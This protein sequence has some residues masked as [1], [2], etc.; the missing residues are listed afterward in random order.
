MSKQRIIRYTVL[1]II[2]LVILIFGLS[3]IGVYNSLVE[4]DENINF[5][6]AEVT[7][8]LKARHDKITLIAGAVNGLQDYA[9]DVYQMITDAR[10]AYNAAYAANDMEGLIEA[11][12]LESLALTSLMAVVEDNPNLGVSNVYTQYISEVSSIESSLQ[13]ARREYNKAI[14]AYRLQIRRFPRN[15]FAKMFGFT[16]EKDYWKLAEGEGDLPVV[17]FS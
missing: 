8:A 1:G 7:N 11:D 12:K 3:I 4:A 15:L 9:L 14:D 13:Y 2:G 17:D 10:A 16:G 5:K 6:Y